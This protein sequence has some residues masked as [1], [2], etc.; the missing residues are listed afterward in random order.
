MT[1]TAMFQSFD[2]KC[3]LRSPSIRLMPVGSVC[4][5]AVTGRSSEMKATRGS[6]RMSSSRASG[7]VAAYPFNAL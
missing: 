1:A 6:R 3:E 4:A 2:E 7:I 5:T